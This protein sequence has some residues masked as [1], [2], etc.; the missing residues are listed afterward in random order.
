MEPS[1]IDPCVYQFGNN[2][3]VSLLN[4]FDL[5]NLS[6][7][8]IG[9]IAKQISV[10]THTTT[11][12][13]LEMFGEKIETMI[14]YPN[15]DEIPEVTIKDEDTF[16]SGGK[17]KFYEGFGD[18]KFNICK[19]CKNDNNVFCKNCKINLCK[20]C[21][22]DC[23][24]EDHDLIDLYSEE[25]YS[26]IEKA[27]INQI[28]KKFLE[29]D[30]GKIPGENS[31]LNFYT[32]DIKFIMIIMT[33]NYKN[34]FNYKNIKEGREYLEK[35]YD[36]YYNNR[37]LKIKY[38]FKKPK[39]KKGKKIKIFGSTFVKNNED[40]L[41]LTINNK[42]SSL[43]SHTII[44]DKDLEVILVQ[45]SKN[46][47]KNISCMFN[48]CKSTLIEF[49]EVDNYELLNLSE[50]TD[51]SYI[52][53]DCTNLEEIDL[54]F[55][56]SMNKIKNIDFLFYNCKNLALISNIESLHTKYITNMDSVF[57][58][59]MKL[60]SLKKFNFSAEG[61]ESFNN[62]FHNCSSLKTLPNISGWDMRNAKTLKG[63]FSGC[64]NLESLPDISK[65]NLENVVNMEEMFAGCRINKPPDFTKC[66]WDLKNLK[67]F[68]K[69]F[70]NSFATKINF[71]NWKI[72]NLE[73]VSKNNIFGDNDVENDDDEVES[74]DENENN[75]E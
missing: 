46:F 44:Y 6:I 45:K 38:C 26:L 74:E 60:K 14:P 1:N 52:F 57:N 28:I 25:K 8:E 62:L 34:Y 64:G 67:Y 75:E 15:I 5:N 12:K 58:N 10:E 35:I 4:G 43:V 11:E 61:V 7:D 73:I 30:N 59:C 54:S 63:M 56:N 9:T 68:D 69:I 51:I 72:G 50:V 23:K 70:Y 42:R 31:I 21:S 47:I 29:E 65:W 2:S 27:K 39:S 13:I 16:T 32:N 22:K 66:K 17:I 53:K 48:G 36:N 40:N 55:L 71:E 20:N 49:S 37:C 33:K 18:K 41:Y 19:K 3:Q 24:N